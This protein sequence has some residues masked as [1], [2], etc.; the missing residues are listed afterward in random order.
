MRPLLA[1]LLSATLFISILLSAQTAIQPNS[2]SFE[3]SPSEAQDLTLNGVWEITDKDELGHPENLSAQPSPMHGDNRTNTA[4]LRKSI[5]VILNEPWTDTGMKVGKGAPLT[6]SASGVMNWF[7][8]GCPGTPSNCT[9]TPDGRPWSVCESFGGGL[10]ARGLNCWS[11]IGRI[12]DGPVFQVGSSLNHFTAASSGELFLG[13][14][15]AVGAFADNTGEWNAEITVNGAGLTRF[16]IAPAARGFTMCVTEDEKTC[17]DRTAWSGSFGSDPSRLKLMPTFPA[18]GTVAFLIILDPDH[19][20]GPRGIYIRSYPG[21]YDVPCDQ[22]NSFHVVWEFAELRGE[23]AVRRLEDYKS[24]ACWLRIAANAG[25]TTAK[26]LLQ[27]MGRR[28]QT[29]SSQTVEVSPEVSRQA[30]STACPSYVSDPAVSAFDAWQKGEDFAHIEGDGLFGILNWGHT[31]E[32]LSW[33]CKSAAGGNGNAAFEIGK[34]FEDGYTINSTDPTGR[35]QTTHVP[36][37]KAL[38]F[39]WYQLA[40]ARGYTRGMIRVGEYYVAAPDGSGIS[41]DVDRGLDWVRK[42]AI[43]GDTEAEMMMWYA[44]RSGGWHESKFPPIPKSGRTVDDW[45]G[46]VRK[47]LDQYRS[48][49][50]DSMDLMVGMLPTQAGERAPARAYIELI[51]NQGEEVCV[52][53]LGAARPKEDETA[54]SELRDLLGGGMVNTWSYTLTFIPGSTKAIIRR[55]TLAEAVAEGMESLAPIVRA[56]TPYFASGKQ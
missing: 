45:L 41:K 27:E 46:L 32:A 14:N 22:A 1:L 33:Y 34:I 4:Q 35:I 36:S 16:L 24:A 19:L 13:V 5:K 49:C 30:I 38:A 29:A 37:N 21:A 18:N 11:L 2:Q 26:E 8:G 51:R 43:K 17:L 54:L 55:E 40:A 44:Y 25:D 50:T 48:D 42:A 23:D 6:V 7:T 47:H 3:G 31:P 56:M 52:L 9:V 12:G 10:I 53:V 28:Q 39:Y 20:R 15:D